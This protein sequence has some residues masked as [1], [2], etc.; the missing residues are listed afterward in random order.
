MTEV[1]ANID[2]Y[3]NIDEQKYK[4]VNEESVKKNFVSR[5]KLDITDKLNQRGFIIKKCDVN[6]DQE[7]NIKKIE[8]CID[9]IDNDDT[10]ITYVTQIAKFINEEYDV[11]IDKITVIEE[12]I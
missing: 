5:L 2:D 4:T 9:K 12:G 3:E 6:I 1:T 7:Y 8:I 10:K 11:E